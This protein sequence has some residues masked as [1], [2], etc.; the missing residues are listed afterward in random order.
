MR[1]EILMQEK[2]GEICNKKNLQTNETRHQTHVFY[3]F[4]KGWQISL[5]EG[6]HFFKKIG[7][8]IFKEPEFV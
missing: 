5:R 4:E 3:P 8:Y 2:L 1:S 6:M 7:A